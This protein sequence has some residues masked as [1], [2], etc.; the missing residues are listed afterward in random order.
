MNPW[1]KKIKSHA[2]YNATLT[3]GVAFYKKLIP[4]KYTG[5]I[6]TTKVFFIRPFKTVVKCNPDT[7][8]LSTHAQEWYRVSSQYSSLSIFPVF[9]QIIIKCDL[10]CYIFKWGYVS[11]HPE[12]Y[13]LES[14][15]A[16]EVNISGLSMARLL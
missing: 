4:A 6:Q 15:V 11:Q 2:L 3:V 5:L 10:I 7:L 9:S 14:I 1:A 16:G 13:C 12:P 8:V